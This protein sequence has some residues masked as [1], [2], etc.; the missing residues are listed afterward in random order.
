MTKQ[1]RG[2]PLGLLRGLGRSPGEGSGGEWRMVPGS[3]ALD[4]ALL[5]GKAREESGPP[6]PY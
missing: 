2:R 4:V 5:R 6:E 1:I 3:R